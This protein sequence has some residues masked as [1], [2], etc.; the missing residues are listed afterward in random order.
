MGLEIAL[1][2]DEL[3]CIAQGEDLRLC[4]PSIG[5]KPCIGVSELDNY[6]RYLA[7]DGMDALSKSMEKMILNSD[8][9]RMIDIN[10]IRMQKDIKTNKYTS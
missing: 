10:A 4:I 7:D 3:F 2:A 9:S 1:S 6:N 5:F 8:I